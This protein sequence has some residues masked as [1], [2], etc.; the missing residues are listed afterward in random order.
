MRIVKTEIRKN[1]KL[2]ECDDISIMQAATQAS[3]LGLGPNQHYIIPCGG[4][5]QLQISCKGMT[6]LARSMETIERD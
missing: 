3:Q 5:A 6:E 1:P 2:A 4:N